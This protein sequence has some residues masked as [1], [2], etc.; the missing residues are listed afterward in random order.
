[1]NFAVALL[2]RACG[3]CPIRSYLPI[4]LLSPLNSTIDSANLP[5]RPVFMGGKLREWDL[6]EV[7]EALI[8]SEFSARVRLDPG[9]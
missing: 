4:A 2:S 9:P 5:N 8:S 3:V 7:A 6:A 1:M